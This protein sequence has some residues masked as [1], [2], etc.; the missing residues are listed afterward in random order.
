MSRIAVLAAPGLPLP[1]AI[2]DMLAAYRGA[3]ETLLATGAAAGLAHSGPGGIAAH[4]AGLLVL[5]GLLYGSG[6][7]ASLPEPPTGDDAA[8]LAALITRL[9]VE[10]A[11]ARVNGDFAFAWIPSDG[12]GITL[13]RDPFGM[14]PLFYAALPGGGWAAS[15]QPR[16]LLRLPGIPATP[17]RA[18][19][20][21]FGAMH[22][23][24]IDAEPARSPYAA[25]AQV[26]AGM[27]V[28]LGRD[29]A[30]RMTRWF[31]AEDAPEL[32]GDEPRLAEELRAL[33]LDAVGIRLA[34]FPNR[35]FTLS[36]GMDSS[37][38]LA[39][40]VE[41]EGR[42][43]IA[44]STL[45]VDETYD[46]RR[47]IA[48][49][50][51]R[52][53][54][55][56]RQVVL[57]NT[58]DLMADVDRMIGLHDEPVATATWLSHLRLARQAAGEGFAALFGGLGGDELNAGEYEYFPM[59]FADLRAAGEEAALER[60]IAAWAHHHDHPIFRKS[61]AIARELMNRLTDPARPGHCLA[62]RARLD[63]YKH[64]LSPDFAEFR[65][66]APPMEAPYRSYLKTRTWQDLTR[67]T[68][69]CCIRAED[70]H[71]AAFGLPPVLPFLD[72]R[73]VR[74]MYRVPG[75]MKIRDGVTK[76]LLRE[77]TRGL[78]PEATRTR[79]KK[80]GWNAPAHLWFTGPGAAMLR[81]LTHSAL[82]DDL[83]L[84][85]RGGVLA[86]ID[87][88]ERIVTSGAAEENHMMF[89]WPYFNMMRWQAWLKAEG[90]REPLG[91][92]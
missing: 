48:D 28:R 89:L 14:R 21:R 51:A 44:F 38:V 11:L 73:L 54:G 27:V 45:Y 72:P 39:S 2:G 3:P 6:H 71:G 65:D 63:R 10:A 80:T 49:M 7:L 18:F 43:Q 82:F 29:G 62:D 53:V 87:A 58:I 30:A 92:S 37:S 50:L 84:Y 91:T 59:H 19:L 24:L 67:E 35:A 86:I 25:I 1:A 26:P 64:V 12:T 52:H 74:F 57:P 69:P 46:E 60:E 83:G 34:R 79:V 90:W 32:V 75:T 88:H 55:E 61:P 66:Y 15:S 13:A 5:D 40:A 68:L 8:I 81:D 76:R 47:E 36:G 42:P 33:L 20:A 56:W 77:A 22:Y 70:R 85:D 78:L 16:G 4:P 9:G 41:I 23:R 17:D 31:D